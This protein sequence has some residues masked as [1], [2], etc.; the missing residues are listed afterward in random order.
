MNKILLLISCLFLGSA[1]LKAFTE[2]EVQNIIK[3]N[4]TIHQLDSDL[5][6]V[7]SILKNFLTAEQKDVLIK[8]QRE[9]LKERNQ[10][11][12]EKDLS[13]L[14]EERVGNL[15]VRIRENQKPFLE[16][17]ITGHPTIDKEN[18]EVLLK[19]CPTLACEAYAIYF[20]SQKFPRDEEKKKVIETKLL[21]LL[22]KVNPSR[23]YETSEGL[24]FG[25]DPLENLLIYS[26]VILPSDVE[27]HPG[28]TVPLWLVLEHPKILDYDTGTCYNPYGISVIA[29]DHMENLPSYKLFNNS[30]DTLFVG[31]WDEG[32]MYRSFY[33]SQ[34]R[35]RDFL[36]FAPEKIELYEN[37][38]TALPFSLANDSLE[39]WAF[40]GPWNF[41]KYN[42]FKMAFEKMAKELKVYYESHDFLKKYAPDA[43]HYLN[44]YVHFNYDSSTTIV[45]EKAYQVFRKPG[46]SLEDLKKSIKDFS[47]EDW[48][49]ALSYAIL[50]NYGTDVLE[51]LIQSGATI[52]AKVDDETPLIKASNRPEILKYLILKGAKLEDQTGFGK[53][54]LFYAIQFNNLE[55]VKILVENGANLNANLN[56]EEDKEV[57]DNY[58]D[59]KEILG[60][61]PL[62]YSMR[63]GSENLTKYF[64]EKGA[65]LK[66]V[67]MEAIKKWMQ[68][69][70]RHVGEE[71]INKRFEAHQSMIESHKKL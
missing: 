45:S 58:Y 11:T 8:E 7:Y 3:Q 50:N 6:V 4:E 48:N 2:K 10:A 36:S 14:Y 26:E 13:A 32:T 52:N 41:I 57:D 61:K 27:S 63:Y 62:A 71:N 64:L 30:L 42:E 69:D 54:A 20:E 9:W 16:K 51:W 43:T 15:K 47:Q 22:S 19:K 56:K 33:S 37:G 67:S 5:N 29:E 40:L 44:T 21:K 70:E 28:L 17:I 46:Q 1:P 18:A 60:F 39:R 49:A 34:R 66:E 65:T 31:N 59:L 55:S 24:K 53:T 38:K 12:T 25:S 23:K 35:M 68:D